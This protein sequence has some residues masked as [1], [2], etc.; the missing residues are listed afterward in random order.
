MTAVRAGEP[1]DGWLRVCAVDEIPPLGARVLRRP[2]GDIALFR[3]ADA[4][5]FALRD[6]CPHRGGPL[7]QGIVF[8]RAVACPLHSWNIA[9]ASGRAL[10]PDVGCTP[11]FDVCVV[12]G[13]VFLDP[14]PRTEHAV[15]SHEPGER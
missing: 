13:F 11:R 15:A 6:R 7:S 12:D 8:G 5:F 2:D 3:T 1:W 10:E 9:L 4:E 14:T